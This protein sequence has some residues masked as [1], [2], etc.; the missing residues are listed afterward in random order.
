MTN[1]NALNISKRGVRIYIGNNIVSSL[2]FYFSH[3]DTQ[4]HFNH[5]AVYDI[6]FL[7]STNL[8][9]N[10]SRFAIFFCFK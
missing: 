9:S 5:F 6:L 1:R 8:F 10:G 4:T 3:I 7:R 2:L